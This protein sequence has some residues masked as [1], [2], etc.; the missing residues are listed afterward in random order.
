MYPVFLLK[1]VDILRLWLKSYKMNR[2]ITGTP[3][4]VYG[5]L[6]LLRAIIKGLLSV[7]HVL[8]PEEKLLYADAVLYKLRT[9]VKEPFENRASRMIN[10]PSVAKTPRNILVCVSFQWFFFFSCEVF[11]DLTPICNEKTKAHCRR[12]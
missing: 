4:Y 3:A 9:E 10:D 1:F 5:L 2:H 7:S 6:P 12:F 8:R 11:M